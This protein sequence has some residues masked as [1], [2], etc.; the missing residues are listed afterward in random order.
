[1]PYFMSTLTKKKLLTQLEKVH[2][3]ELLLILAN[4]T[5]DTVKK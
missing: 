4:I 5:K 3:T 1:M 2:Y